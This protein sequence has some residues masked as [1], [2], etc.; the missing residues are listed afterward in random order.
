MPHP[1]LVRYRRIA[2]GVTGATAI[3]TG[4]ALFAACQSEQVLNTD[5]TGADE[6]QTAQPQSPEE[7]SSTSESSPATED[8]QP[9]EQEQTALGMV[10][11][12]IDPDHEDLPL[13]ATQPRDYCWKDPVDLAIEAV[14]VMQTW[15]AAEDWS[16]ADAEERATY[17]MHPDRAEQVYSPEMPAGQEWDAAV[18]NEAIALTEITLIE[19]HE[20]DHGV[21]LNAE[22]GWA[23]ESGW[24][25]TGSTRFWALTTTENP[26]DTDCL[27]V[28]DYTWMS[29]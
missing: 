6:P 25:A 18:Q 1:E 7:A 26:D 27:V 28:W 5:P 21:E 15:D 17:L 22:W 11:Y 12:N 16:E 24:T 4:L 2:L 14:T 3:I 23:A 13:G 29:R 20:E 9:Q 19:G 10:D 8:D